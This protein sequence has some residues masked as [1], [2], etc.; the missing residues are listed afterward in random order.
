MPAQNDTSPVIRS[1][2]RT[3]RSPRAPTVRYQPAAG[4]H[5][6]SLSPDEH[7]EIATFL[8]H[9]PSS[10]TRRATSVPPGLTLS[11][12]SVPRWFPSSAAYY[13]RRS[14]G[15]P[16]TVP[17]GLPPLP[18][19]TTHRLPSDSV[20]GVAHTSLYGDIVIGIP[21]KKRFLFDAQVRAVNQFCYLKTSPLYEIYYCSADVLTRYD[22]VTKAIGLVY[23]Y[24]LS[25]SQLSLPHVDLL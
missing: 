23:V 1:R 7:A 11:R 5:R 18:P 24:K 16:A 21:H 20:V 4:I 19:T 9:E 6:S 8:Q 25:G 2:P 10:L 17:T 22:T 12:P 3:P 13:G 15:V 14:Y